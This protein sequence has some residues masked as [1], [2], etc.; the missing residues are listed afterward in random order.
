MDKKNKTGSNVPSFNLNYVKDT[1]KPYFNCLLESVRMSYGDTIVKQLINKPEFLDLFSPKK[2]NE[3]E[4][5]LGIQD[6]ISMG[7]AESSFV[8]P[9]QMQ[10]IQKLICSTQ[11]NNLY[12]PEI[13]LS[14]PVFYNTT[15]NKCGTTR[16]PLS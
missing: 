5:Y 7:L 2:T 3:N 11:A 10:F 8:M 15:S 16:P 13:T 12:D 1:D 6:E 4:M 14:S 9:N